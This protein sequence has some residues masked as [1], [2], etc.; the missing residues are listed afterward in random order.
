MGNLQGK[1]TVFKSKDGSL[2]KNISQVKK[3]KKKPLKAIRDILWE[4]HFGKS[5]IGNCYCCNEQIQYNKNYE[6]GHIEAEARGGKTEINNLKP[7]CR[8]CNRSMGTMNMEEFKKR[9]TNDKEHIEDDKETKLADVNEKND[10]QDYYDSEYYSMKLDFLIANKTNNSTAKF[11]KHVKKATELYD[12]LISKGYDVYQVPVD[13]DIPLCVYII[14][15]TPDF[16]KPRTKEEFEKYFTFSI[17]KYVAMIHDYN[18]NE[19]PFDVDGL[20]DKKIIRHL[21]EQLYIKL[22]DHE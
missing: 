5:L 1:S 6:A 22:L 10:L 19:M 15:Y 7:V 18:S 9:L 8:T 13:C 16:L 3:Y 11:Y 20:Y 14:R 2:E 21:T 12:N 17:L 4:I